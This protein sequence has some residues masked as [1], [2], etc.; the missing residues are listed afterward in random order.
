MTGEPA[1]DVTVVTDTA[2]FAALEGEWDDLHRNAPEALP[3]ESWAF[4]FSWW[5]AHDEPCMLRLIT[6]RERGTGLLVGLMPLML[7]RRRGL[8]TLVF[9]VDNEPLDLLARDGWGPAVEAAARAALR[10]LP[11]WS[12]AELRPVRPGARVSRVVDRWRG[13]ASGPSSP[14][15]PTSRRRPRTS[16][17]AR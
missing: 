13:P 8:R 7:L 5:Q 17:C 15:T 11:G 1:L 3:H 9:L 12:L 4:L 6:L 2:G 16:C 10:A 14:A